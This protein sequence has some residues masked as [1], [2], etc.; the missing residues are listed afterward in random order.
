MTSHA[1]RKTAATQLDEAG[2]PGRQT[3]DQL[4]GSKV[5]MT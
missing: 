1:L 2:P 3:T 5:S 4:G